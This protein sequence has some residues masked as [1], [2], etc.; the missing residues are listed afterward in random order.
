MPYPM[1]QNLQIYNT[2]ERKK[3]A[4]H[5]LNPPRVGMYVCGPTVYGN[6]HLGHARAAITFDIVFRYLTYIGYKVRYVR[7]IT[8][9]GHLV[10]DADS[11]EDKLGKRAKLEELEPMEIAQ[12]YL[13]SYHEDLDRLNVKRPSIEPRATGHI[14]EQIEMIQKIMKAGYAYESE[15]SVYFDLVA[16]SKNYPFGILSGRVL[17]ELIAGAGN[18]RRELEGQIEKKNAVDFALWKKANSDHIMRW[19]SPWGEGFPGWHIECSAMSNKYLGDEFDIHGG[20]IDLLFPHHESEIAQSTACN[21]KNLS[22]FWMHNNMI[23]IEGQKMGK[24][25]GN[26]ISLKEFYSGK[27]PLLSK[28]FSPMT[29]RFF[30]LQGHYR[31]TLDFSSTA[32]EASEKGLKRLMSSYFLLDKIK[33][34]STEGNYHSIEQIKINCFNAINDDFNTPIVLA[35]LFEASKIIN[36]IYAGEAL[37]SKK[38]ILE[39]KALFDSFLFDILGMKVEEEATTDLEPLLNLLIELRNTAKINKEYTTS[40]SIRIRLGE[41]G[42]QLNDS[43]NETTWSKI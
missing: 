34:S 14:P 6:A 7:N 39:I 9:V 15:G 27:H 20:G 29:I 26:S 1:L 32:L 16:Y 22:L 30:M 21:G 42:Y 12:K 13:D 28:P 24:S 37:S 31:S 38:E 40:D 33:Y 18:L 19:N 11:G 3:Q 23:T 17:E 5:A 25:L 35:E 41:I 8:D 10:N 36:M 4:F 43:K 2:L